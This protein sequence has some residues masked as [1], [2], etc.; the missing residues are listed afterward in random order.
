MKTC[1]LTLGLLA[2]LVIRAPGQF[3]KDRSDLPELA[4][5]AGSRLAVDYEKKWLAWC[6]RACIQP[7]ITRLGKSPDVNEQAAKVVRRGI[8]LLKGHAERD[9]SYTSADLVKD[10]EELLKKGVDDPV[11]FWLQCWAIHDSTRDYP[12]CV[13]AF[14]RGYNHK[15]AQTILPVVRY[16]MIVT[17][18]DI[19]RDAGQKGDDRTYDKPLMEAARLSL[20]D[21]S[22]REEDEEVMVENLVPLFYEEVFTTDEKKVAEICQTPLKSA[23]ARLMLEGAFELRKAWLAR[24]HDWAGQV[25]PEGWEGFEERMKNAAG[26][27]RAAW[28][29]HAEYP[30]PATNMLD[31]SIV[32][33]SVV[34][35]ESA[36]WLNRALTAQFDYL[37]AYRSWLNGLLPRWGGSH[38]KMLDFGI[39]CARTH[40]HDTAVPDFFFKILGDVLDDST[41][42]RKVFEDVSVRETTLAL[43]EQ[44]VKD[45]RSDGERENALSML[46]GYAWACADYARATEVLKA[47]PKPFTRPVKMALLPFHSHERIIRGESE[48]YAHDLNKAWKTAEAAWEAKDLETAA[49][50]YEALLLL[51]G[52]KDNDLVASRLATARFEQEFSKGGWVSLNIEP[53]LLC[54]QLDKGNWSATADGVLT[55]V[56]LGDSAYLLHNGRIGDNFQL[57]GVFEIQQPRFDHGLGIMIGYGRNEEGARWFTCLQL[58]AGKGSMIHLQDGKYSS[59]VAAVRTGD[60]IQH[61]EFLIT[62]R[63]GLITYAINGCEVYRECQ[64]YDVL[65]PFPPLGMMKDGRM[66]FGH[67]LFPS[68]LVTRILKV[69]SRRLP[70]EMM[71]RAPAAEAPAPEQEMSAQQMLD[72]LDETTWGFSMAEN[73]PE[74]AQVSFFSGAREFRFFRSEGDRHKHAFAVPDGSTVRLAEGNVLEFNADRTRFIIHDWPGKGQQRY[75]RLKTRPQPEAALIAL[76]QATTDEATDAA[77]KARFQN[78]RW[79]RPDSTLEFSGDGRWHEEWVVRPWDGKWMVQ[80]DSEVVVAKA[81]NDVQHFR[82]SQDGQT[83]T[84]TD[85]TEWKRVAE[86]K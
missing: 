21:D 68:G 83:L 57:R 64:A 48:L 59:S 54:W 84:R 62:S 28:E 44:R 74:V 10:C 7:F 77:R 31:I 3:I 66:G 41:L 61:S 79:K 39:M 71:A 5:A 38:E 85:G 23:Y 13:A 67:T 75:C 2:L 40:R 51:P 1:I 46:G 53:R 86:L 65:E 26:K 12:A 49:R 22:Y 6:E 37:P 35:E 81:D 34:E 24:G 56:G 69:E 60:S 30:Q 42:G 17:F 20:L 16:L 11:I 19:R 18:E 72:Y 58:H 32:A 9:F 33:R 36:E 4:Q 15:L 25:P 78:T 55:N 52:G 50:E 45:A 76:R 82:I 70:E 43:S 8:P 73:E 14:K 47:Q 27:F 63:R 29:L 80:S